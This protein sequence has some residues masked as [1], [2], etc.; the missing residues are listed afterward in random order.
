MIR[1][2]L[3]TV[4]GFEGYW[5]RH[6]LM[7]GLRS[8]AFGAFLLAHRMPTRATFLRSHAGRRAPRQAHMFSTGYCP[9]PLALTGALGP[10]GVGV[11]P[12][13]VACAA[14]PADDLPDF[15]L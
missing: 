6:F 2:A 14:A 3:I 15:I 4:R 8:V 5:H 11:P 1:R 7:P 9:D 12:G 10:P 13:C